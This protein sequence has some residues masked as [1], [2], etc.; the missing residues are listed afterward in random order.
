[1]RRPFSPSSR[2]FT[3]VELLVVIA[4]IGILVSLLLPAVQS[5]REAARRTQCLNNVK[6]M[7]L[8]LLNYEAANRIFPPS[9]TWPD[10]KVAGPELGPNWVIMVLPYIED[11][12]VYDSFDFSMPIN[13]DV[14][15]R[16]RSVSLSVML[17][18]SDGFNSGKFSGSESSK[19]TIYGDNWG[20]GNYAANASL[21]L[22][23]LADGASNYGWNDTN[24][25]GI[26]GANASLRIGQIVDGTSKTVMVGEIRAGV[27]S[28][29]TRGVW[30]M[31]GGCPSALWGHGWN[32]DDN[33]PNNLGGAADDVH[34]CSDI[35]TKFG[36]L[37]IVRE[38]MGCAGVDAPN[39]QQTMRS[40]H[41][42]SVNVCMADGSVRSLNDS[43]QLGYQCCSVWDRINLSADEGIIGDGSY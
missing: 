12:G 24:K 30:A 1:M 32:G 35:W 16:P 2:G 38:K 27:I 18:P 5:A 23:T 31:S 42:G 14:N 26:M 8:A 43:I 3:L 19:T 13:S 7:G 33:G 20:R 28:F 10:G 37:E 39:I 15:E 41:L 40:Q 22:M 36:Y 4:I 17:C 25:R 34:S 21:G 11:T 6:Q 9:S 29:D